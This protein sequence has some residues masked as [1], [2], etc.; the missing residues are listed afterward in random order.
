MLQLKNNSTEIL[1]LNHATVDIRTDSSQ[2]SKLVKNEGINIERKNKSSKYL[3]EN[4]STS[5]LTFGGSGNLAPLISKSGL[6]V[7]LASNLG[8]DQ[9]GRLFYRAMEIEGVNLKY[10]NMQESLETAV[11]FIT[12][13]DN[14]SRGG[15]VYFPNANDDV[16]FEKFKKA[17]EDLNPNILHYMYVGLSKGGDIRGGRDLAKFLEWNQERGILT[18]IDSHTLTTDIQSAIDS[19]RKI[20]KYNLLNSILPS[21]D[22]FFVS[23]DEAKLIANSLDYLPNYTPQNKDFYFEFL[24]LLIKNNL[25]GGKREKLFGV[26]NKQ[27]AYA[28]S[29]SNLNVGNPFQIESKFKEGQIIDLVGAGD[30]FR[31]GLLSYINKNLIDFKRGD[32]DIIEAIQMGNLFASKFIKS[33]LDKRYSLIQPYDHMLAELR[34]KHA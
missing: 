7:A 16:D 2:I 24:D 8:N 30:S 32:L 1:I 10:I 26:T 5:V 25:G 3:N 34:N 31:A 21:T 22:V 29:A 18:S 23:S 14:N 12:N 4:T 19:K 15:M 33:P 27:G 6:E 20:K 17:T 13:S 11:T 9:N 28:I